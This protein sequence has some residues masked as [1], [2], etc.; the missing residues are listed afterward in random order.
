MWGWKGVS[1]EGFG[2]V[3]AWGRSGCGAGKPEVSRFG[4]GKQQYIVVPSKLDEISED[5]PPLPASGS[6]GSAFWEK[7]APLNH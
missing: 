7:T 5:I 2:V 1:A 3:S 6:Y 4:R